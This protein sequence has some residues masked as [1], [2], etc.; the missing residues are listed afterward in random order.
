MKFS[1]FLVSALAVSTLTACGNL[2]EV[3]DEGTSE[4]LVWPKIED[5][6]FNHN[7]T[8]YGSWPNWDNIR[9]IERGMNKDQLYNLIGRPHFA[10]GLFGVREWDYVFNYRENGEH[11]V[12]QYKILFDT[13]MN[14]QNFFWYPNG[15]NGSLSFNL[16]SDVLFDFDK[17]NLTEKGLATIDAVAKELKEVG[18]KEVKVSG[19]TDPIG[20]VEYNLALSKRRAEQA[21]ARLIQQGVKANIEAIGYGKAYQ[22]KFCNGV[23]GQALKDCLRA[24][25]RVEIA[26]SGVVETEKMPNQEGGIVGP[27]ILYKK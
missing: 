19:H 11:K 21:K 22:V 26:S 7:G 14:A 16:K 12:C 3:T 27:A 4:H 5:S 15:C 25:R 18:A 2:S 13:E 8:Q 24:N 6:T 17:Y 23:T 20:S 1:Y 9:M 10:E